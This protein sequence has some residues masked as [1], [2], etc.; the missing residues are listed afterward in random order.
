[1][2]IGGLGRAPGGIHH[3]APTA[4]AGPIY[5]KVTR[6]EKDQSSRGP[7]ACRNSNGALSRPAT[8]NQH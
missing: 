4:D 2:S 6:L 8:T 7:G 3:R 5:L 1:M